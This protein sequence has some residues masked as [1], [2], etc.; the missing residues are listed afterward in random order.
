MSEH[1]P[2]IFDFIYTATMMSGTIRAVL[3]IVAFSVVGG[4]ISFLVK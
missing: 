2:S 4:G 3:F 1:K